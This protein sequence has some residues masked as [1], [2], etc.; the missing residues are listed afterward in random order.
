[1]VQFITYWNCL[2]LLLF[3]SSNTTKDSIFY[4]YTRHINGFAAILEEEVAAEIS[5]KNQEPYPLLSSSVFS[6]LCFLFLIVY[7][8]PFVH[9]ASRAPQSVVSVREP[10]EKAT[11][12]SIMGFHG[13]R[14]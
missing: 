6:P 2:S 9:T 8:Y 3:C 13:A 7:L 1:M 11:H 10:W 5:S 4:S 14:A 12:H